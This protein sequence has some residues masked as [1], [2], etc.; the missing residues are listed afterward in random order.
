[1][2]EPRGDTDSLSEFSA[3]D[4]E[5]IHLAG[6]IQPHGFL[7]AFDEEG[8]RLVQASENVRELLGRDAASML[9][10]TLE[11]IFGVDFARRVR[12]ASRDAQFSQCAVLIDRWMTLVAGEPRRFALLGHRFGGRLILEGETLCRE[13]ADQLVDVNHQLQGLLGQVETAHSVDA[14]LQLIASEVRRITGFDRALVY[15]FDPD[16]H[17]HVIAEDRNDVLPSYMH[18]HFPAS[19]IPKQARELYRVNRLRLI[20]NADYQPV[21]LCGLPEE[22]GHPLDLSLSTLRSVS[23]VHREYMRN[24]GTGASFSI[25]LIRGGELWGLISCHHREPR[26]VSFGVRMTC[27][28]LAQVLSLQLSV[29]EQAEAMSRRMRLQGILTP[30]VAAMARHERLVEGIEACKDDL[31]RIVGA[32]GAAVIE[33]D[34]I[35]CYGCVPPEEQ[36]RALVQ[37][38]NERGDEEVIAISELS[39]TFPAAQAYS[40]AASGVLALS[41]SRVRH[42]WMLWFRREVVETVTWGGDPTKPHSVSA[43]GVERLHPRKSFEQWR[44][45]VRGRALPWRDAEIETA[46]EF[47]VAVV[48]IVLRGAEMLA[49]LSEELTR[50]NKELEN[51]SYTVSHDLRAPFR[52]I[53]GYAELLKID[54]SAMLDDEGR[55]FLEYVL[56]GAKYAGRLVDNILGFSRMGRVTLMITT[57][58][59]DE[60]VAEM[61]KQIRVEPAGRKIEWTLS[62]LPH[63][64][65]DQA[66]LCRVW[67][68]LFEN[69][70]K[71]TRDRPVT[72]IEVWAE[73]ADAE[74]VFHVKDNGVGFD[75]TYKDKLFGMFQRLHAWEEFEGT[76]I[77]LASVRRIVA[78]H[79]GRVWAASVLNESATFSFSLPKKPSPTNPLYA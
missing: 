4:N 42:S 5:P 57:V 11:E 76:G 65:A 7:L 30:M 33:E 46:R 53:R 1:M 47:R 59:L 27:G 24:M 52:H 21:K 3:C 74:H 55:Q 6:S 43:D 63:V 32:D 73:D 37:W 12:L 51:F 14:L 35:V 72:R 48:D 78:R 71:F 79:G 44:E 50:T 29:R 77:G 64:H 45:Q 2:S 15:R 58:A 16:W 13:E 20:A 54:K 68:N 25:S 36:V 75:E 28:L 70:V 17:G 40:A 62:P 61:I 22:A 41:V 19:D 39:K 9:G 10:R 34:K 38:L 31:L 67:Q 23:P 66:L 69:A 49:Q 26:Q 18:L 56:S 8:A 60:L